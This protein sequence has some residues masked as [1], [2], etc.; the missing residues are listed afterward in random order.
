MPNVQKAVRRVR[1]SKKVK[2]RK[3]ATKDKKTT[4]KVPNPGSEEAGRLGCLC[5]I[6]DNGYGRGWM[7]GMDLDDGSVF[8]ISGDCK[9]HNKPKETDPED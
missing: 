8:V 5:P 3:V 7:S 1:K 4:S 9:L 6:M 2:S